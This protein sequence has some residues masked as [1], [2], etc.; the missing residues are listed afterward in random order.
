M[1]NIQKPT[2]MHYRDN[3]KYRDIVTHDNHYQF[4]LVLPIL[5]LGCPF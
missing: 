1:K 4:N 2:K 5:S 3:I